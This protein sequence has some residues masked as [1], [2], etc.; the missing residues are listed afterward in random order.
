[1]FYG[2]V[3]KYVPGKLWPILYQASVVG[4]S[5]GS[6]IKGTVAA[7]L[8]MMLI[9]FFSSATLGAALLVA[10]ESP[11]LSLL[12]IVA[13]YWLAMLSITGCFVSDAIRMIITTT[14]LRWDRLTT[15]CSRAEADFSLMA[16]C[17]AWFLV[18]IAA[19]FLMLTAVFHLSSSEMMVV[20]AHLLLA[21]IVGTLTVV[22]PAGLGVREMIFVGL[23][24]IWSDGLP[25]EKL[26]A[27]AVI[28]RLWQV[29]QD[30][31]G[32]TL[33]FLFAFARRRLI[34]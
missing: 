22:V 29:L 2:Q 17:A 31:S 1:L 6:A 26:M 30:V 7:N 21:W 12:V 3:T 13:G 28:S 24:T 32:G 5:T 16:S 14:G 33:L 23:G 19:Y 10:S 9:A 8:D 18:P 4:G 11:V 27:I 34:N 20:T 15:T 25:E